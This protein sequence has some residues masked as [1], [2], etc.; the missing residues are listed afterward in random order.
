MGLGLEE[1]PGWLAGA[2]G[3][4]GAGLLM[5]FFRVFWPSIRESLSGQ[6][7]QWRSE[8]RYIAQLEDARDK[9]AEERDEAVRKYTELYHRFANVEAQMKV[10]E[11]KLDQAQ[12]EISRLVAEMRRRGWGVDETDN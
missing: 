11:Y 9:L 7:T 10:M 8:N 2:G 5:F 12:H 6:R 4:T 3:A 1:M